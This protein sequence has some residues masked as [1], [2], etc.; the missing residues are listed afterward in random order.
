MDALR[1]SKLA[2]LDTKAELHWW[3]VYGLIF[4]VY[5]LHRFE[6]ST[7]YGTGK[8]VLE[9][10]ITF[11]MICNDLFYLGFAISTSITGTHIGNKNNGH[12][13][14]SFL[15]YTAEQMITV[16]DYISPRYSLLQQTKRHLFPF[17]FL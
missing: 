12:V 17:H 2:M 10:F 3:I 8:C 13:C 7:D 4:G 9:K 15:N 14:T 16:L 11:M 1:N 6:A 5:Y